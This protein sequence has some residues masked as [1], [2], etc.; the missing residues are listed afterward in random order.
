[1]YTSLSSAHLPSRHLES[2]H[3]G[4]KTLRAPSADHRPA[5]PG[6]LLEP[7]DQSGPIDFPLVADHGDVRQP[8]A[9]DDRVA[10]AVGVRIGVDA[11]HRAYAVGKN[12]AQ[13]DPRIAEG[14][15]EAQR[16]AL[17]AAGDAAATYLGQALDRMLAD[18][19]AAVGRELGVE[20]H[21]LPV[22]QPQ[23]VDIA[24]EATRDLAEIEDAGQLGE[25]EL[26]HLDIGGYPR[27]GTEQVLEAQVGDAHGTVEDTQR[28]AAV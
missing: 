1:M 10:V 17:Q 8:A 2:V 28:Q 5:A 11:P 19:S 3:A 24:V 25:V 9:F 12:A 6:G 15:E 26:P 18:L 4:T 14:L 13:A 16:D 27:F 21:R 23:P 20:C 22:D 7:V